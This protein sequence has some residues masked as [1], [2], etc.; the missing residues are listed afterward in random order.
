[1]LKTIPCGDLRTEH[2]GQTVTLAGWVHRRRDHGGL[3][4]IDLRDSRGL[5]QV[6]FNPADAPDAHREAEQL[7][8]EWVVQVT[9]KV[10]R[11]P[12]GTANPALATG[13][14][15]V[16]ASALHVLNPAKTPPFEVNEDAPVDE[17]LRLQYRYLDLRRPQMRHNITVRHRAVKYIRDFLD[18]RGFLE[19]E[20]PILIKSTPEGARD[21]LV[22]SRVHPGSFYA[23]PQSPQQLKQLLMVGGIER[24]FQIARCF[25]DEDQ[26]ADRQPEFSQLD[27]EM[28]FVERDDVIGLM[29]ELYT[30]LAESVAPHKR[31]ITPVPR[32]SYPEAMARYGTDKPDLRFGL[33]LVELTDLAARTEFRVFRDAVAK[34]GVVVGFAAPGMAG[35]SRRE[36][37]ELIALARSHGLGGL[38]TIGLD[39]KAAALEAMTV[40]QVRSSAGRALGLEDV[41]GLA[42]RTGAKPGDMLLMAAGPLEIVGPALGHV[43]QRVGHQLGPADQN[44]LAFAFITD[45]P[46]L[47]WNGDLSRWQAVHHPFTSPTDDGWNSLESDPGSVTAKAYDLVCNGSELGGGSIRI[48]QR[49]LQE[50]LFKVMGYSA[51]EVRSEFSHLLDAFEY[52]APPHGG[53]AGGIERLVTM[54]VEDAESIR[55]VT[56]FPKN[57]AAVDLL[58][59]APAPVN[60]KQLRELHLQLLPKPKAESETKDR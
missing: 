33:E 39:E 31:V 55:D 2:Q 17:A 41:L 23:L 12:E 54:L 1:M 21:Y 49:E 35:L 48:H 18:A 22:P 25:R 16:T 28:S 40:E 50:R 51:E 10:Q 30:S 19:V 52:G 46:L 7:R 5:A 36:S 9:G 57:Q 6:V 34:G 60:D 4:F 45:F 24:Y 38:V 43:R 20:T 47:E 29:E 32:L 3:V 13:E 27:L 8:G 59:G 56:A 26:R 15:E 42:V 37:D 44:I 53:F 14:V 11:R 58:F